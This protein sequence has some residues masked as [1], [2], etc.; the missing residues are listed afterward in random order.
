M[1]ADLKIG[2]I[3]GGAV[4]RAV[5]AYYGNVKIYDKYKPQDRIEDVAAADFIFVAVPTPYQDAPDLIEMDDAVINIVQHLPNPKE[6]VVIIKSTVI[7]GTTENYQKQYPQ[8]NF[9]FNP[10]FLTEKVAIEDFKKPDKQLV[11][12]TEKTRELAQKVLEILPDAPYQKVLPARDAEMA[13][14]AINAFYAFKVIFGNQIYDLCEVAGADYNLVRAGLAADP[15]IIDSHFDIFHSGYRGYDGKCLPKD[16]KT[17]TWLA[18]QK[19]VDL[20]FLEQ[21]ISINERL[22]EQKNYG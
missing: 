1:T 7:P 9:V 12:F 18:K 22:K 11:G 10:E 19:N 20:E 5:A 16:I 4:G 2:V 6:Q 3:G 17:L 21:I 14:Y 15:R 8:I 13:K